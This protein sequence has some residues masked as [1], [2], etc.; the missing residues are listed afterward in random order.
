MKSFAFLILFNPVIEY[1][2]FLLPIVLRYSNFKVILWQL[3]FMLN[4]NAPNN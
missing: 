1:V 3:T 4:C 2:R